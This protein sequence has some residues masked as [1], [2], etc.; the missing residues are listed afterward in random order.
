MVRPHLEYASPVWNPYMRKEVKAVED[1]E[2][3][4]MRVIT[5]RWDTGYQDLLCMVNIPSLES[6]RLHSS[7]CST[8]LCTVY[9]SFLQTLF[10]SDPIFSSG[11]TDS[12]Y[13]LCQPFTPQMPSTILCATYCKHLELPP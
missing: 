10:R 9:A 7:T 4:S 13:L 1:V 11:L 2:K 6:R 8:K 5:R 3:F 12:I